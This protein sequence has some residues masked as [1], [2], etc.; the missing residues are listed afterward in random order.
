ME[1]QMAGNRVRPISCIWVLDWVASTRTANPWDVIGLNLWSLS[2]ACASSWSTNTTPLTLVPTWSG[3]KW[4]EG[5]AVL[6]AKHPVRNL[7][8][9]GASWHCFFG[10]LILPGK[11]FGRLVAKLVFV[12]RPGSDLD[13]QFILLDEPD[14][15]FGCI[16][17]R[18]G[19]WWL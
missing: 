12:L 18:S 7:E 19:H 15:R 8:I 16:C 6:L 2:M 5:G 3:A 4:P 1:M 11:R 13:I 17:L 10:T 14:Y 9:A